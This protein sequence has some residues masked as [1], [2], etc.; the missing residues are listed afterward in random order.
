LRFIA[1]FAA[2][3]EKGNLIETKMRKLLSFSTLASMAVLFC[4]STGL[5]AQDDAQ[6]EGLEHQEDKKETVI[7][8]ED[9]ESEGH[10]E[11]DGEFD[12]QTVIMHHIQDSHSFHIYGEGHDAVSVPLPVILF[13][14]KGLVTFMSS[15]FHHDAH[16][17]TVVEAN[18]QYF[19]NY[20]EDIFQLDS[21][22]EELNFD[23]EG[24]PTNT[25]PLDFS[26]T[27]NVFSLFLAG[28][29]MFLI[30]GTAARKYKQSGHRVPRGI[31]S[32]VEPL[33][34]FVRDE[35]A[36]PQLGGGKYQRFM[37]FLLTMFFLIWIINLMGLI[38]VFPFSANLSGNIAFTLGMSLIALIVV[39]FSGNK[40][41]W[42]HIFAPNP[43]W[44]WPILFPIEF[45]SNVVIK[46]FALMIRLFA[47]ITAG[48]IIV[49][50]LISLVFIFQ[51]VAAA[52]VAVPFA[53]FIS[54]LELLVAALQAF[55][56]TLLTAL[57]LGQAV[58]EDHH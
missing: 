22:A 41:Y 33:I 40:Y 51:S 28:I 26:I 14:D 17:E 6:H 35:I 37:P 12:P 49:L 57:F 50:S 30:F 19:V 53:L 27:K 11:D 43:W 3:F 56:F 7:S 54:V 39:N 25:E 5:R 18:G 36:K 52:A 32:F 23:E 4:F 44:L 13:T 34:I 10:V 45:A 20:H 21:P 29:I 8:K 47:N 55:I 46:F 58:A 2:I 24:H 9:V 48:H 42:K 1:T 31:A 16:G 15:A 38:P